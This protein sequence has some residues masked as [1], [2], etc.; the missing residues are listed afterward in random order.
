MTYQDSYD[1]ALRWT[2]EYEE[3]QERIRTAEM[4]KK[5][6]E[7]DWLEALYQ[8]RVKEGKEGAA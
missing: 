6:E 8:Q 4:W 3:R 5:R 1:E 7:E 2:L